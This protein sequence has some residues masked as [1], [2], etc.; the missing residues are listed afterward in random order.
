MAEPLVV[1]AASL[2]RLVMVLLITDDWPDCDRVTV[3]ITTELLSSLVLLD[4]PLS[5]VL[6]ESWSPSLLVGLCVVRLGLLLVL[7]VW[8]SL[9]PGALDVFGTELLAGPDVGDGLLHVGD[10]D[11]DG[12]PLLDSWS[13][14][15]LGPRLV[16][17]HVTGVEVTPPVGPLSLPDAVLLLL[18]LP[19]LLLLLL[20]FWRA[21]MRCLDTG[22]RAS[23]SLSGMNPRLYSSLDEPALA[24]STSSEH[25]TA[26][27]NFILYYY[28][29]TNER[30]EGK[31]KV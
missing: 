15:V 21:T 5:V 23:S 17:V 7:E 25:T 10:C 31:G 28:R 19:P 8:W 22:S 11:D 29:R 16:V 30:I 9:E 20:L 18:L 4:L 2:L 13:L 1:D 27:E 6:D 26:A 12:P 14:V 24:P 3:T